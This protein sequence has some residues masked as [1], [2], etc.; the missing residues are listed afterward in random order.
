MSLVSD[1]FDYCKHPLRELHFLTTWKKISEVIVF[2]CICDLYLPRKNVFRIILFSVVSVIFFFF[3]LGGGD[4]CMLGFFFVCG[5][6][7]S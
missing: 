2:S 7:N 1:A 4:V 5:H 6:D 3:F